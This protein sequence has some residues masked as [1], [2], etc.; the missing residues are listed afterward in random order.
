M[1]V[2][3]IESGNHRG[4]YIVEIDGV[5]KIKT[6]ADILELQEKEKQSEIKVK[7]EPITFPDNNIESTVEAPVAVEEVPKKKKPRKKK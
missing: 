7:S 5:K 1:N 3:K 2:T 6:Y 4:D